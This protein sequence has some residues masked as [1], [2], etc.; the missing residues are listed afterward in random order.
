MNKLVTKDEIIKV[1]E[2]FSKEEKEMM[3]A[4]AV[5]EGSGV[6][7]WAE[8]QY[9]GGGLCCPLQDIWGRFQNYDDFD[10]DEFIKIYNVIEEIY[11]DKMTEFVSSMNHN[12]V[13]KYLKRTE[14]IINTINKCSLYR[15]LVDPKEYLDMYEK[16]MN[17]FKIQV[18]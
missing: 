5:F 4:D 11:F 10:I 12:T 16:F 15:L 2:N 14:G 3:H 6:P 18:T 9:A 1:Y 8:D 7:G 13:Q 17:T